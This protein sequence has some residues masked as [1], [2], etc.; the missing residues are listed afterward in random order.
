[1]T[2]EACPMRA[3]AQVRLLRYCQSLYKMHGVAANV[4]LLKPYKG[5]CN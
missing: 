3:H 1:M 5:A 4:Q 2:R